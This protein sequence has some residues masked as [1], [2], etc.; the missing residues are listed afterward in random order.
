MDRGWRVCGILYF[1]ECRTH[2]ILQDMGVEEVVI[3]TSGILHTT[4]S[5]R[6]R[7]KKKSKASETLSY[8]DFSV[9]GGAGG[10]P[11]VTSIL[12]A[13]LRISFSNR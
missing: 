13:S 11:R 12:S 3:V 7:I 10:R 9:S 6:N 4:E 8:Y 1:I 2:H 5:Y